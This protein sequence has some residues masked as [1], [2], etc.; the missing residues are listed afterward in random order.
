MMFL[1]LPTMLPAGHGETRLYLALW[2]QR[3]EEYCKLVAS[4]GSVTRPFLKT[5]KQTQSTTPVNTA[6]ECIHA[7]EMAICDFEG[8][9]EQA[10]L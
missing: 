4:Q 8:P 6:C 5:N 7:G 9:P 3:Q 10:S 2:R 1:V